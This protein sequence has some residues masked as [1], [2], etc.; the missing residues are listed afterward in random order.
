M[1]RDLHS[2]ISCVLG[3]MS[4]AANG[5]MVSPR[6]AVAAR[7]AHRT[8]A[9][10]Q[11][12]LLHTRPSPPSAR[13]QVLPRLGH[14]RALVAPLRLTGNPRAG[15]SR[16]VPSATPRRTSTTF[17]P[18][19]ARSPPPHLPGARAPALPRHSSR[20]GDTSGLRETARA[21]H[22]ANHRASRHQVGARGS[23]SLPPRRTASSTD[24]GALLKAIPGD[25]A[26]FA[27]R[28]LA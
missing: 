22:R 12:R 23:S 17:A 6:E 4:A 3:K 1:R 2:G 5:G 21:F 20:V 26:H 25:Q 7:A 18:R 14:P 13:L 11:R 16:A 28:N 10:I 9:L 27:G 8:E 24:I 19:T 15:H